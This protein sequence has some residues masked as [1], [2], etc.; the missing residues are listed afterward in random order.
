MKGHV[1]GIGDNNPDG[2]WDCGVCGPRCQAE[3]GRR[4][5]RRRFWG[6]DEVEERRRG[7]SRSREDNDE[8]PPP[9]LKKASLAVVVVVVAL[10]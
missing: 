5:P 6:R 2:W 3:G 9:R 8:E 1:P 7:R 10:G 4:S